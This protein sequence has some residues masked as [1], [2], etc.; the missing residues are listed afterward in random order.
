MSYQITR[1]NLLP[2][3]ILSSL[4]GM[5]HILEGFDHLLFLFTLLIARQSFKQYAALISAFTIA[6]SLT[7]T[8]TVIGW[9]D[10]SPNIVEPAIALSICYVAIENIIRKKLRTGWMMT[11]VF[12]LIHG[13]GFADILQEMNIPKHELAFDL[14]SFNLGIEAVQLGIVVK[15][16]R[17]H[18][19]FLQRWKMLRQAIQI[20]SYCSIYIRCYFVMRRHFMNA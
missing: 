2:V 6:H 20:G 8:L 3:G 7:L 14:I 19:L 5:N 16:L 4:S 12:G 11:F 1:V 18:I 13:M 17:M 10:L 9:I 15:L